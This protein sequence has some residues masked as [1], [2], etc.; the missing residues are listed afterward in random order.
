MALVNCLMF[1]WNNPEAG[2]IALLRELFEEQGVYAVFQLEEGE[3]GTIHVQGYLELKKRTRFT[4]IAGL[5]PWHIEKRRGSQGQA[6][7]YCT[8]EDTRKEGPFHVGKPKKQGAR[9][10]ISAITTALKN[11][12]RL[13]SHWENDECAP[14]MVKYSRGLERCATYWAQKRAK[15]WRNVQ[16]ISLTG[17]TGVGKS[18][19]VLYFPDGSRRTNV[20][21]LT[22]D[23]ENIWFDG[24]DGEAVL[25]I[26]DFY[27][28]IKYG[29]LLRLLDGHEC[30]LS[31]KGGQAY[32]EWTQVWITSNKE[33]Y[34]WYK[35]GC[36]EALQR[37]LDTGK[38][39]TMDED[40]PAVLGIPEGEA[41][42]DVVEGVEGDDG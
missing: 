5:L 21:V 36:P 7:A 15:N 42:P 18:R 39:W 19:H 10:D 23:A 12:K 1:T 29:Y 26:D 28:W 4:T 31:V 24:Y 9:T 40:V 13:S 35:D 32:A 25:L 41:A 17:A 2:Y 34:E 14:T 22:K 33:P 37:R 20:Y 6:I 11:G 8:K 27:G 16:V 38:Q 3:Q 30:R